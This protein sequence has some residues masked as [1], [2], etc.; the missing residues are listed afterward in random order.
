MAAGSQGIGDWGAVGSQGAEEP[1]DCGV[2]ESGDKGAKE[3]G[4]YG[5]REPRSQETME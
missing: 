2:R 4:I 3:P 1:G 5:I